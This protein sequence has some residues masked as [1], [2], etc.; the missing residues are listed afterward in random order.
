MLKLLNYFAYFVYHFQHV[1]M[2]GGLHENEGSRV[3]HFWNFKRPQ[4][5]SDLEFCVIII[6]TIKACKVRSNSRD[7]S[8]LPSKTL[9][10]KEVSGR[11]TSGKMIRSDHYK[12]LPIRD[13]MKSVNQKVSMMAIILEFGLPKKTRGT[14]KIQNSPSKILPA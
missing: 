7:H 8:L 3:L 14:G 4:E 9:G 1:R 5:A 13:A 11:E 2:W 12:F 6:I 10:G